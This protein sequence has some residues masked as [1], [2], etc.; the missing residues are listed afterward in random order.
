MGM[1]DTAVTGLL[2][3]QR[4]LAVTSNNIANV[5]T[6]GYSRQVVTLSTR[7]PQQAGNGFIGKGV[8]V[9]DIKRIHDDF[10]NAQVRSSNT[11]NGAVGAYLE[12]AQRIDNL[13]ADIVYGLLGMTLLFGVSLGLD[14]L[15]KFTANVR[16]AAHKLDT[17]L[18]AQRVIAVVSVGLDITPVA[19]QE[20]QRH[21]TRTRGVILIN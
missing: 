21:L 12:L 2:A 4:G 8:Q 1:L 5:N 19:V 20:C 10:L 6:P 15:Y 7:E 13:L 17:R 16:P 9:T 14:H 11:A 3:S 18:S